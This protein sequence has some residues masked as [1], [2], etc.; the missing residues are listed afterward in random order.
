MMKIY[1]PPSLTE[2]GAFGERT[3]GPF[4]TPLHDWLWYGIH[5]P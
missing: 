4:T 2:I 3:L 5:R 1:V